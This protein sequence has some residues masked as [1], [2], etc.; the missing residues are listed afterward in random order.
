MF[1]IAGVRV[2]DSNVRALGASCVACKGKPDNWRLRRSL[3]AQ[4]GPNMYKCCA[5]LEL[6]QPEIIITNNIITVNKI[7]YLGK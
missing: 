5:S 6:M 3:D 1:C 7:K 2:I 4:L